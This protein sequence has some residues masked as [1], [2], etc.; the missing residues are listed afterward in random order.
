MPN[1]ISF[2]WADDEPRPCDWGDNE[3]AL[4]DLKKLQNL[5]LHSFVAETPEPIL[6]H[7]TELE[8]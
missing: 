1:L 2:A 3:V 5:R 4:L 6:S 8:R 7:F